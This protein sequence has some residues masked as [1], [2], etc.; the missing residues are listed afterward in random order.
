M[1]KTNGAWVLLISVL[2]SEARF[3]FMFLYLHDLFSQSRLLDSLVHLAVP[4]LFHP[5]AGERLLC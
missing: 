3:L 1:L 2:C 5:L 4:L